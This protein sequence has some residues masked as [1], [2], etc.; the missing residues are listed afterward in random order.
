MITRWQVDPLKQASKKSSSVV[1]GE[2]LYSTID[3]LIYTG[4]IQIQI[5]IQILPQWWGI[6]FVWEYFSFNFNIL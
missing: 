3:V 5:Q 2:M 4:R 6:F 1:G